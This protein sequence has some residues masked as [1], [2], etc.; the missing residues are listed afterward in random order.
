[1]MPRAW[2]LY[3]RWST[4]LLLLGCLAACTAFKP[5]VQAP[6]TS[7]ELPPR[8]VALPSANYRGVPCYLH[9]VRWPEETLGVIARW[10]TG[11]SRHA[12]TLERITPN[13]RANDLRPG[14]TVFIPLELA[15]R[16][17][18]LPRHYARRF[19][20]PAQPPPAGQPPRSAPA[21]AGLPD[22]DGPPSPY[23]PRTFPE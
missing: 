9:E 1:M 21:P 12:R 18:P 19:G 8:K 2:R 6:G 5:Q 20:K 15:R 17:D 13:L 4:G 3:C 22:D 7:G 14:D 10:Y 11:H 23:G 16:S